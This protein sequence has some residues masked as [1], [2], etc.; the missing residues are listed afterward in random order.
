MAL[1]DFILEYAL[2]VSY[3]AYR[4]T[5][6]VL[7]L[8]IGLFCVSKVGSWIC[9]RKLCV[10]VGQRLV[11]RADDVI[12]ELSS[13]RSRLKGPGLGTPQPAPTWLRGPGVIVKYS[14]LIGRQHG[15]A[16]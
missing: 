3:S 12:A 14:S 7:G 13:T 5:F 16:E 10:L 15:P 9:Y 1:I 4:N 11:L 6:L 2:S 8:V